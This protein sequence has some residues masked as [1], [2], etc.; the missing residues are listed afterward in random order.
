M[1]MRYLRGLIGIIVVTNLAAWG[2]SQATKH[3][4]PVIVIAPAVAQSQTAAVTVAEA[5][6]LMATS[7]VEVTSTSNQ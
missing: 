3:T 2:L 1:N 4:P 5:E 6:V 7:S